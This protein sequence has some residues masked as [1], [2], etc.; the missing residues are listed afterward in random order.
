MKKRHGIFTVFAV[1]FIAALFT[2]TGCP[3]EDDGGS[4]GVSKPAKLTDSAT[5]QQALD[6]VDEII[7]YCNAH[8]GTVNNQVKSQVTA[9]KSSLQSVGSS[10]W[11]TAKTTFIQSINTGIDILE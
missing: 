7:S 6:K 2:F 11:N 5:Y 4:S 3:A 9:S 1:L 8:P 10:G